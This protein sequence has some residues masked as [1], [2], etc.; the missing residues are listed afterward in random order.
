MMGVSVNT[1]TAREVMPMKKEDENSPHDKYAGQ[2]P[3]DGLHNLH[4]TASEKESLQNS[5][6]Q[7]LESARLLRSH[8]K[9]ALAQGEPIPERYQLAV[10]GMSK[11]VDRVLNRKDIKTEAGE[12]NIGLFDGSQVL[13]DLHIA[14]GVT[15]ELRCRLIAHPDEIFSISPSRFE[16]LIMDRLIEMG[17][18]V[19]QVGK[20]ST[21]DGGIDVVFWPR[22]GDGIPILGA[23][24]IK[25]R[26]R[27]D[28]KCGVEVVRSMAGVLERHR[29][30]FNLGMVVTNSS[31]TKDAKWFVQPI[32]LFLR[33]RDG[34][35]IQRWVKGQ[36]NTDRQ[37]REIPDQIKLA[38]NLVV[39][40]RGK[41][42]R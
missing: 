6:S 7:I 23:V 32:E 28:S 20:T 15:D 35:D 37:R 14:T 40:L 10:W 2:I 42:P 12:L 39:D 13:S 25:H 24:Q 17:Y 3:D 41:R 21:P 19:A 5:H 27:P 4:L 38:R 11:E 36:F 9:I 26:S 8:V 18:E 30:Q 29:G 31:F 34:D 1:R 22:V 33:L 16:E